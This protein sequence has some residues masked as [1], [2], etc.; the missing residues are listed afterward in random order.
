MHNGWNVLF[1]APSV[2]IGVV[3]MHVIQILPSP[4]KAFNDQMKFAS[5][6]QSCTW[7]HGQLDLPQFIRGLPLGDGCFIDIINPV[8]YISSN[9]GLK[10]QYNHENII[11]HHKLMD[12]V[13]FLH[14]YYA[15]L[16]WCY[17]RRHHSFRTSIYTR[18]YHQDGG[19]K[20]GNMRE[21]GTMR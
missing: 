18:T 3:A 4:C 15:I 20:D 9:T 19:R 1:F 21:I 11:Q 7:F 13:G 8:Y 12:R 14:D 2:R 10:A 6:S 17:K 16:L 5:S